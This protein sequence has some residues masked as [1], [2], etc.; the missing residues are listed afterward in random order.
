MKLYKS[1][2]NTLTNKA[3]GMLSRTQEHCQGCCRQ[4]RKEYKPQKTTAT[5][6]SKQRACKIAKIIQ[7][8][9]LCSTRNTRLHGCCWQSY[10]GTTLTMGHFTP[11]NNLEPQESTLVGLKYYHSAY[12][13]EME[14][15]YGDFLDEINGYLCGSGSRVRRT[16]DSS[17]HGF[18][19][20][21]RLSGPF[22][23]RWVDKR[24][25]VGSHVGGQRGCSPPE[26]LSRLLHQMLSFHSK[27]KTKERWQLDPTHT[28]WA[29][30]GMNPSKV[31]RLNWRW[32]KTK[33]CLEK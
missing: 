5:S 23:S 33:L 19:N 18:C 13:G 3:R 17:W 16:L 27:M 15:Y 29:Q 2:A 32:G 28:S 7:G 8:C 31:W 21:D 1:I 25:K 6:T 10:F 12:Y 14:T 11:P 9:L 26:A 30:W 4:H 20:G 24:T 22:F